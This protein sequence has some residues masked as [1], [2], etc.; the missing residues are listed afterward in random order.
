MANPFKSVPVKLDQIVPIGLLDQQ[1]K[2]ISSKEIE[3]LAVEKFRKS[4]KGIT[5]LD[6]REKFRINKKRAQRKL[7]NCCEK[8]P[9]PSEKKVL[10]TPEKHKPQQY[11]P[12]C[13]KADVIEYLKKNSVPV[14]PTEVGHSKH[15]LSNALEQQKANS[16]LEVLMSIPIIPLD[17]HKIQLQTTTNR[18]AYDAFNTDLIRGNKAKPHEERIGK[19]LV[20]YL[21]YPYGKV[22]VYIACSNNPFRLETQEDEALLFSF[23]GQV[24]DRLLNLL[25]DISESQVPSILD[26]CLIECDISKDIEVSNKMH[27]MGPNIQLKYANRVF[28]FYIK[29]LGEKA[30]GRIEESVKFQVPLFEALNSIRNPY[31]ELKEE[32]IAEI[33][34]MISYR[35]QLNTAA[36]AGYRRFYDPTWTENN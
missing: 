10:F 35:T 13:L 6:V 28:R 1:R 7:K 18:E 19:A 24:R 12:I 8:D 30:V 4:K 31:K 27:Y 17:I 36:A 2:N 20:T 16:M 21:I 25:R 3:D 33:K 9:F 5:F 14:D 11:Y 34:N 23:F 15:P 26:W 29:S 22:M 32:L